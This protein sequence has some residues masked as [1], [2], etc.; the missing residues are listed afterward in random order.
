MWRCVPFV[1]LV[2]PKGDW[3]GCVW[4]WTGKGGGS[5]T[6]VRTLPCGP[7][8]SPLSL[9]FQRASGTCE[10]GGGGWDGGVSPGPAGPGGANPFGLS[11]GGH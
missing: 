8:H 11:Q 7:S 1:S 6:R 10:G 5:Q 3:G 4:G 9:P 2:V